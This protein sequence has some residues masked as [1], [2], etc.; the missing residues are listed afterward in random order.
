[1][2]VMSL[3]R[4]QA[5]AEQLAKLG[6]SGWDSRS[7]L[8][9]VEGLAA[10]DVM[11]AGGGQVTADVE[12]VVTGRV[13]GEETSRSSSRS[14]PLYLSL[15]SSER[16]VRASTPVVQSLAPKV[17]AGKAKVAESGVVRAIA[18]SDDRRG[19]EPLA[20]Q[21]LAHQAQCCI[22]VAPG[23]NENVEGLAF[24]INGAPQIHLP[25]GN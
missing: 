22:L 3:S 9:G 6:R 15:S 14:K 23:L 21:Q 13:A 11:D 2:I 4:R 12:G 8:P 20:F 16:H 24:I 1:M 5:R 7:R 17:E 25:T 19:Y 10:Q 18:I